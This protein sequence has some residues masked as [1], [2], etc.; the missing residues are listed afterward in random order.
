MIE[1]TK[2]S[3]RDYR[4]LD[5]LSASDLRV[6][7]TDGRKEF[8]KRAILKKKKEDRDSRAILIGSA[9]HCLLLERENFEEKFYMSICSE[10]PTGNMK[11]FVD[12]LYKYT[13]LNTNEDGEV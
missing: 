9:S 1:G 12:N 13:L 6:Y 7:A 8:Y 4:A 5:I 10:E 2:R 11:K 3:E